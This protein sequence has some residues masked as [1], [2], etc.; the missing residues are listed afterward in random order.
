[1]KEDIS[2]ALCITLDSKPTSSTISYTDGE[3]TVNFAVGAFV[4][5][6][7]SDAGSYEFWK[8]ANLSE[9]T[10]TWVKMYD[11]RW[12]DVSIETTYNKDFE[13]VNITGGTTLNA[14]NSEADNIKFVNSSSGSVR[15][16]FDQTVSGACTLVSALATS[17]FTLTS[18]AAA[19]FTRV[20][21][22]EY[23]LTQLFGITIF[24]D[25]A[26]A[27]REGEW[28]LT[29]S[30]TGQ[31]VLMEI[32]EIRQWNESIVSEMTTAQLNEMYPDV[33]QG[34]AVVA[35]TIGKIY[36]KANQYNMWVATDCVD[37]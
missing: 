35:K 32:Q 37:V 11:T 27:N 23:R 20:S 2:Q 36:E 34:F 15:I 1:M 7:D 9:S 18:G 33:P 31:P 19:E 13:I 21:S 30:V 24:P 10:A 26:N 6:Y 28:A 5:V 17:E 14:I 29:V 25:L 16:V 4:R 3:S 12:G 22:S 8:L